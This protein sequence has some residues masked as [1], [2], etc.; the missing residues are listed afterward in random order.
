MCYI[1]VYIIYVYLFGGCGG[2]GGEKYRAA[3]LEFSGR[4]SERSSRCI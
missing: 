1:D 3:R 2:W 4:Y